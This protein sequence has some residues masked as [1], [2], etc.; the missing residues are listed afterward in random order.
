MEVAGVVDVSLFLDKSSHLM[1]S[2]VWLIV[3]VLADE[4]FV[5][6]GSGGG[7]VRLEW[8]AVEA[9]AS[10]CHRLMGDVEDADQCCIVFVIDTWIDL[11]FYVIKVLL[12]WCLLCRQLGAA[13]TATNG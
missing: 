6:L 4:V 10:S 7:R 5:D 9:V 11:D 2:L 12:L 1:C 8:M 3:D 13:W